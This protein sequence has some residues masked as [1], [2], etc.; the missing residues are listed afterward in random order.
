M[1]NHA[2]QQD[3]YVI[4]LPDGM[5]DQ[6]KADAL[7]NDR[8]MNAEIIA[9]LSGAQANLRDQFAMEAMGLTISEIYSEQSGGYVEAALRA[10]EFA[11]AMLAAR[12]G[13]AS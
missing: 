11:D 8:S 2:Q 6:I 12:E 9:R 7:A 13:G 3:K 10:Y 4:R 1:S 5:R